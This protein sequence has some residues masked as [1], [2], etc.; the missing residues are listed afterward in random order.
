MNTLEA[1]STKI[2]KNLQTQLAIKNINAVPKIDKIIVNAGVGDSRVIGHGRF[3]INRAT[4]ETNFIAAIAQC[5]AA[6]Q[7]FRAQ[8]SGQLVVI[9][10]M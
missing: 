3:N 8:N 5:E 9:S 6:M 4:A 7:I 10:S 1:F 2:L